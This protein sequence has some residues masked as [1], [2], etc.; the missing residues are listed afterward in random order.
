MATVEDAAKYVD[1]KLTPEEAENSPLTLD[2]ANDWSMNLTPAD[3]KA[4]RVAGQK[5]EESK[6]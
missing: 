3:K 2:Y 1:G 5:S 4:E 6:D